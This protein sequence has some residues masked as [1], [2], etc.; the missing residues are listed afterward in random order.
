M[1]CLLVLLKEKWPGS[2]EAEFLVASSR[3]NKPLLF[4]AAANGEADIADLLLNKGI[5]PR[6]TYKGK[7]AVQVVGERKKKLSALIGSVESEI[8]ALEKLAHV[9]SAPG[10][11]DKVKK[12]AQLEVMRNALLYFNR[13]EELLRKKVEALDVHDKIKA[14]ATQKKREARRLRETAI[15]ADL[16]KVRA[17]RLAHEAK[18]LKEK[19]DAEVAA[20]SAR[21]AEA[22]RK[23]TEQ[24]AKKKAEKDAY[25]Q[26]LQKARDEMAREAECKKLEAEERGLMARA[27]KD[28]RSRL[29]KLARELREREDSQRSE[30]KRSGPARHVLAAVAT[31]GSGPVSRQHTQASFNDAARRGDIKAMQAC[32]DQ[33]LNING[34]SNAAITPLLAG[35]RFGPPEAIR[36]L[37]DKGADCNQQNAVGDHPIITAVQR[38]LN[39]EVHGEAIFNLLNEPKYKSRVD[40]RVVLTTFG[41]KLAKKEDE[42]G[43]LRVRIGELQVVSAAR[44][45]PA[46]AGPAA[47]AGAAGK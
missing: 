19:E 29:E 21:A 8:A 36:F 18:E 10:A 16:A 41:Q 24:S 27:E 13:T 5:D 20:A 23:S 2:S 12:Q 7:T 14:E 42:A 3:G 22:A 40:M 37:L 30:S 33:G 1:E 4:L 9:A 38:Y 17:E 34:V 6:S 47:L 44:P 28:D 43:Q 35:I 39:D 45:S 25:E 31:A 32:L 15:R 11:A 26:A 46:A